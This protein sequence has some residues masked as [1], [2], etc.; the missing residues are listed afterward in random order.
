[1]TD[2]PNGEIRDLLPDL[3]HARL[4]A[5]ERDRVK[6]HIAGCQDCTAE[7]ALLER[8]RAS[9]GR[10]ASV[11]VE[12]VVSALP[13]AGR[14]GSRWTRSIGLRIAAGLVGL[15]AAASWFQFTR[16]DVTPRSGTQVAVIAPETT[17][18]TEKIV[19]PVVSE[20][21]RSVA[22]KPPVVASRQISLDDDLTDLSDGELRSLLGALDSFE[23]VTRVEPAALDPIIVSESR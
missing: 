1:M 12:R 13:R 4:D 17:W 18:T 21:A 2:C 8:I 7:V 10:G 14:A 6:A 16:G 11:N 22:A 20:S 5:G 3:V 23:A 15:I 9:A 19:L